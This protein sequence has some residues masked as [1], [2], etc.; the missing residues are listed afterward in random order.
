[1]SVPYRFLQNLALSALVSFIPTGVVLAQQNPIIVG[2][3]APP[4]VASGPFGP[5]I[6]PYGYGGYGAS[7]YGYGS[8]YPYQS[9]NPSTQ[10]L[11]SNSSQPT[12]PG[13][14]NLPIG[15][16]GGGQGGG[17][18]G[19]QGGGQNGGGGSGFGGGKDPAVGASYD[20]TQNPN[21][22]LYKR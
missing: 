13:Q 16:G 14:F 11:S 9:Y 3:Q 6:S 4:P 20:I 17:G 15:Q 12:M 10:Q 5:S 7:P 1:M 19:G 2:T 18:Q 8:G 22:P 21:S